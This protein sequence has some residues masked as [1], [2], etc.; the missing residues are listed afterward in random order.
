MATDTG[1]ARKAPRSRTR[2]LELERRA[3]FVIDLWNRRP[4]TTYDEAIAAVCERF[5]VK[6]RTAQTA[7]ARAGEL[8]RELAS[9]LDV[10]RIINHQWDLYERALADKRYAVCRRI[11]ADMAV[12]KGIA[13]PSPIVNVNNSITI[14]HYAH[15]QVLQLTPVQRD[16]RL[17]ELET[18]QLAQGSHGGA[19]GPAPV[20]LEFQAPTSDDE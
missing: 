10:G 18:R 20:V 2:H 4:R 3:K 7:I 13:K 9:S 12:V 17:R 6:D 16:N 1:Q 19:T 5:D 11:L 8:F 14:D 15:V